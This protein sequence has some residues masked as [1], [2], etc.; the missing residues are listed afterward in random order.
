MPKAALIHPSTLK[1]AFALQE[2]KVS[3]YSPLKKP[4]VKKMYDAVPAKA[5]IL[6][7][8]L[9]IA[10][11]VQAL[12]WAIAEQEFA[13][14]ILRI[15]EKPAAARKAIENQPRR[16]EPSKA[17]L[18]GH[19]AKRLVKAPTK[20]KKTPAKKPATASAPTRASKTTRAT[21]ASA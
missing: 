20:V 15:L 7:R 6:T 5:D 4:V 19:L 18:L 14:D 12:G 2:S 1:R 10:N 17:Y 3:G 8:A 16:L 9:V 13:M 11:G 21:K